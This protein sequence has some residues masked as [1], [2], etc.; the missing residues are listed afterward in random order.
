MKNEI[1]IRTDVN[2]SAE[3]HQA[4][5]LAGQSIPLGPELEPVDTSIIGKAVII[6]RVSKP[7]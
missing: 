2:L 5:V 3:E 7:K 1:K 6:D 4:T